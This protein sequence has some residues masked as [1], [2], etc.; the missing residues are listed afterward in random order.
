MSIWF[1]P[2]IQVLTDWTMQILTLLGTWLSG[3]GTL[4][5]AFIALWLGLRGSRVKLRAFADL[6][7]VAAD[8]RSVVGTGE[9]ERGLYIQ[10]T[11]GGER[12]VT[13]ISVGW[14]VGWRVS[15]RW[16]RRFAIN[17][18]ALN[19]CPKT[20]SHGES[21]SFYTS[22]SEQPD[23]MRNFSAAFI[24]NTTRRH[25]KT[26]RVQI[27]TSVGHTENVI[28]AESFLKEL[29]EAGKSGDC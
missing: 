27:H 24:K 15:K 14:C 29:E 1:D 19:Q 2:E 10:V 8:L 9:L 5:A 26:L 12:P 25:V 23:W 6:R 11:N 18:T 3:L 20:L 4:A 22:F 17:P 28:P 7:L 13:I 21:A 16:N